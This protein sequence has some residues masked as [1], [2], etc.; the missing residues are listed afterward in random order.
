ML[1][2][3]G[4]NKYLNTGNVL[5][6]IRQQTTFFAKKLH[7]CDD[8]TSGTDKPDDKEINPMTLQSEYWEKLYLAPELNSG[9]ITQLIEENLISFTRGTTQ[10]VRNFSHQDE[11]GNQEENWSKNPTQAA[12][13]SFQRAL[14]SIKNWHDSLQQTQQQRACHQQN[15]PS[16]HR[17]RN[18][19]RRER[20]NRKR[21]VSFRLRRA[22]H[23]S[24]NKVARV[25]NIWLKHT[26]RLW[27][28][29]G[30]RRVLE[31]IGVRRKPQNL[32]VLQ[33]D[34]S[35]NFFSYGESHTTWAWNIGILL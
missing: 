14:S 26:V 4:P 2:K 23:R 33:L 3:I 24:E 1:P 28:W 5:A 29:Y 31:Q 9:V 12:Q 27:W 18:R 21:K 15:S 11:T 32:L 35:L 25:H 7:D 13:N 6:F 22:T 8:K 16:V 30:R 20:K 10:G 17:S 19:W 34:H